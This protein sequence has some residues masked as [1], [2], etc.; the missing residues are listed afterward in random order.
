[1]IIVILAMFINNKKFVS[2]I[3]DNPVPESVS[4]FYNAKGP[5]PLGWYMEFLKTLLKEK[6]YMFVGVV[7]FFL[8]EIIMMASFCSAIISLKSLI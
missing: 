7:I 1:M 8:I 4:P 5:K 6:K 3:I 2:C